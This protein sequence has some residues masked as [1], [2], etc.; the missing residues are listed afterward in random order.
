MKTK[1]VIETNTDE[2]QFG[3]V[4]E[5]DD[6]IEITH[7][8]ELSQK[9]LQGAVQY[10]KEQIQQNISNDL[11]DIWERLDKIEGIK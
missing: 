2:I 3:Y 10:L 6:W 7:E 4:D 8:T 9:E 1:T 5:N 11:R